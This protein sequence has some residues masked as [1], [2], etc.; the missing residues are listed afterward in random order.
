MKSQSIYSKRIWNTGYEG[1][2]DWWGEV[3]VF[4]RIYK[5]SVIR[6]TVQHDGYINHNVL[7]TSL[8]RE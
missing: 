4:F 6:A 8:I 3:M 1:I 7:C 2:K 5:A